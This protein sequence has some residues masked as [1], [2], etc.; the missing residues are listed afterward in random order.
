MVIVSALASPVFFSI[1]NIT[2]ILRQSA[3][4]GIV[5][6][7]MFLVILTG[8][9][10]L[11]VGS[12]VALTGVLSVGLQREMPL[13]IAVGLA[14]VVGL[15]IGL[16]NGVFIAKRDMPPFVTTLGMMAIARGLTYIYTH[17]GPIPITYP[18]FYFL[19]RGSVGPIP[20]IAI[21][22]LLLSVIV[23]TVLAR[24]TFGRTIMAIGSNAQAVYL[25]G[26]SVSRHIIAVY[27]LSGLI[28]GIGGVLL[29]S[30]LTV[31]TPLMG[32]SMEL[33]AIAANVIGGVSLAGGR[34]TVWGTIMGVLILG[35]LSNMLN[36][37]GVSMF[38]QDVV[39]GAVIIIA[40]VFKGS[41]RR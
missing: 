16:I 39:R 7:A 8:G 22:W 14:V 38:Y 2:N 17:G 10:D 25:S 19:G 21:M 33:E 5:A 4:L 3:V 11:S 12:V 36:L 40:V 30:R 1:I 9:I 41:V 23:A 15:A 31:G 32:V 27:A 6:L 13:V 28:C 26:I 35:L 24:I 34:G 29:A 20:F 18:G 37:M